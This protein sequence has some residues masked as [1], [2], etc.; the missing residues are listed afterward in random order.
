[1]LDELPYVS[2]LDTTEE[3]ERLSADVAIVGGGP[4]G[5]AAA[6]TLLKYSDL[7]VAVIERSS[8][9]SFRIGECLSPSV[10]DSLRYISAE[11]T[12]AESQPCPAHG[13]AA[14][15]G[16]SDLRL[17]DFLFTGRGL[18]W[19]LDRRRFDE[20]LANLAGRRGGIILTQSKI[21]A[22]ER[23]SDGIWHLVIRKA[24]HRRR[25]L[26]NARYV[27]DATGRRASIARGQAAKFESRD[28]LVA[29]SGLYKM[30]GPAPDAGITF[31]EAVPSGWWYTA[32]LPDN[33]TIAVFMTDADIARLHRYREP[34]SWKRHLTQAVHTCDRLQRGQLRT[35]LRLHA[36]YSGLTSP[37]AGAGWIASG[38]AAVTFD[39]LA[40]MGIGYAVLSGIEAGRVAHNIL[41]GSGKLASA[42][43]QSIASHFARYLELR[44]SYYR[45]EQRWPDQPFWNRRH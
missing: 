13:V 3:P 33:Q 41:T 29:I 16:T 42:Y 8:Y 22:A 30:H 17:Q 18:G 14:A 36:A 4:S 23:A 2:G 15:W 44:A 12:L 19:H 5:S 37:P 35:P 11:E 39:P 32:P 21:E 9:A 27:I 45:M 43:A 34:A 40:S 6:L 20:A 26:L 25:I 1:M 38:D 7:R 24:A 28:S 10:A 31:V